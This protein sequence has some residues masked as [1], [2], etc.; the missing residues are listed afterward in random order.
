M[1]LRHVIG[2]LESSR[3][4]KY[5]AMLQIMDK[6][7]MN[8]RPLGNFGSGRMANDGMNWWNEESGRKRENSEKT[9]PY[10]V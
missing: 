8:S 6:A 1:A 10:G 2:Y 3:D 5:A 7:L 4:E 9:R